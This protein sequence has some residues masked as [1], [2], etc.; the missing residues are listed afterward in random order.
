MCRWLLD[1]IF[2]FDQGSRNL[3]FC[4]TFFI[5]SNCKTIFRK[6]TIQYKCNLRN[7]TQSFSNN[8]ASLLTRLS[9]TIGYLYQWIC[10]VTNNWLS[11]V[12]Y[13]VTYYV[14]LL[15]IFVFLLY[16]TLLMDTTYSKSYTVILC[17]VKIQK[18]TFYRWCYNAFSFFK[19]NY[20]QARVG[21]TIHLEEKVLGDSVTP[22]LYSLHK[23]HRAHS[24]RLCYITRFFK[25][26]L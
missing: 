15:K 11:C 20:W 24:A 22:T 4:I 2:S 18:S 23:L 6:R 16:L 13:D 19:R 25:I 17:C 10:C 5:Y 9:M 14:A 1:V 12:T 21:V 8:Y 7:N 3:I 26:I